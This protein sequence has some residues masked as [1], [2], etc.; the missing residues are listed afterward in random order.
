MGNGLYKSQIVV[1]KVSSQPNNPSNNPNTNQQHQQHQQQPHGQ[2]AA[3]IR[4]RRGGRGIG[5][6]DNDMEVG[7]RQNGFQVNGDNEL[8]MNIGN[9]RRLKIN[10]A[11]QN[12]ISL[13]DAFGLA[14]SLRTLVLSRNLLTDLPASLG[15]LIQLKHLD[16]SHNKFATIPDCI[17]SLTNLVEFR[18]ADNCLTEFPAAIL[19]LRNLETL[20]LSSNAQLSELSPETGHFSNLVNLRL[21]KTAITVLPS[22]IALL[23]FLRHVNLDDCPLLTELPELSTLK[24]RTVPTLKELASRVVLRHQLP[25][26]EAV[27]PQEVT[28]YLATS[29]ACSF[30]SGPFFE[31]YEKRYKVVH[32]GSYQVALEFRLCSLHW[33]EEKDHILALFRPLPATSPSKLEQEKLNQISLSYKQAC[34]PHA[35]SSAQSEVVTQNKKKSKGYNPFKKEKK[36]TQTSGE[37]G[38]EAIAMN[39]AVNAANKNNGIFA[40]PSSSSL[41][42]GT[43]PKSPS[44][45]SGFIGGSSISL[46]PPPPSYLKKRKASLSIESGLLSLAPS[47]FAQIEEEQLRFIKSASGSF[48]PRNDILAQ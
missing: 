28:S 14:A 3:Q 10:L 5:G 12:L 35:A 41:V 21:Q 43:L 18:A 47:P 22:E 7:L 40:S 17:S 32:K 24:K 9:T 15:S 8:L 27:I 1:G 48:L 4:R 30:C 29:H 13:T 44:N 6:I 33:N 45:S 25:Y 37:Q 16:L 20:D 42:G 11:Q 19:S 39:A 23:K 38:Q 34:Y 31:H 2:Q 36:A 26:K 46:P